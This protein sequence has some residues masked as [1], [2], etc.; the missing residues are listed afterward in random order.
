M[1]N[2]IKSGF[3][4]FSQNDKL[5]IDANEN[6]IIKAIDADVEEKRAVEQTSVEEALAE[7][8]I[9]DAE[10]EGVEFD[11]GNLLTMDTSSLPLLGLSEEEKQLRIDE[12]L[13]TARAE[14]DVIISKAHDEAEQLRA[15]AF[16][17]AERIKQQAQEEGYQI[18]YNEAIEKASIEVA[19]KE[20]EL[21]HRIQMAEQ[22]LKN[23]EELL[24]KETENQMIDLL[25]QLIPSITGVVIDNQKDVLLYMINAAMHDLDNSKN[26]VIK[27]SSDD[28]S[29]LL[30]RK[31]EIYGALNPA[32]DMEI[33]EDAKL[34]PMQCMIETD[35]GIVDVSL[36]V[37]LDNLITALRL[38]T[39]E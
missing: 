25:C 26:F 34:M 21:D 4:A 8:L 12:F 32:I 2:L 16:D 18:G 37:Q 36:D 24:V 31:E 39:K 19:K 11:D 10:L 33:F 23:R 17:E 22:D 28:Y 20:E 5:V 35:N 13:Q 7:A 9:H 27:V 14:A 3:I 30:E 38:M 6:K 1:S 15:E 29:E